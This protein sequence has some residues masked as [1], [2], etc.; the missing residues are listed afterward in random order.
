VGHRLSPTC[1]ANTEVKDLFSRSRQMPT[2]PSW[3]TAAIDQKPDHC[4]VEVDG[5]RIHLRVWGAAEQPPVVLVHGGG[6]HSGWWDHIAP[7]FSRS[8]RVI[9]P[10]LS[11]HGDSDARSSY[12]LRTWASEVMAAAAAAGAAGRT[13]I[14]GH[15]MGGWVASTAAMNY[16]GQVNSMLVIDSPLWD[17]APEEARLRKHKH[18]QYQT[19]DE[20][21]A[22]FTAVPSQEL[23]LP[24]V[25]QHIA[26]ESVRKTSDGW[27]WKFDPAIFGSEFL[28]PTPAD[29][30]SLE[31]M[32]AAMRCRIGYLRCEA[33]LVPPIMADRIR[34]I[35][36]L[37]GPFVELA[38]AG[39]HPM[40]DQPLPLVATLRTLLEFWSI[41]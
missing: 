11:G 41:T 21:L 20:I 14:I 10:D 26:V 28:E 23:I 30:E 19:R 36:Q 37:R 38:E 17:R 2:E 16:G 22:R 6:A 18:T 39:H 13:T 9:A 27:I 4:D 24:Y 15:S 3:F 8:H 12:D 7:F 5:C 34:S 31:S 29:E 25:R 32:M 33:G 1:I 35:L 40:L